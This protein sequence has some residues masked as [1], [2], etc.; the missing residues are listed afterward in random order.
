MRMIEFQAM[1]RVAIS[2]FCQEDKS[3][4]ERSKK[5]PNSKTWG[6]KK[7]QPFCPN[8]SVVTK[9]CE[10]ILS[11][12]SNGMFLNRDCSATAKQV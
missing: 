2:S 1:R 4:Q 9:S 3:S 7:G 10:P 11:N 6:Q 8:S 5:E 12:I